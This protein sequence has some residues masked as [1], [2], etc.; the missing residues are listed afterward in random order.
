MSNNSPN[1]R[2]S[3][4][5]TQYVKLCTFPTAKISSTTVLYMCKNTKEELPC[6][7]THT[8]TLVFETVSPSR[9][10]AAG[11]TPSSHPG[12][13]PDV[14]A[15]SLQELARTPS[16]RAALPR[17]ACSHDSAVRSGWGQ[18]VM[19]VARAKEEVCWEWIW[20]RHCGCDHSAKEKAVL[21]MG[22]AKVLWV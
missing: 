5:V 17:Q 6:T 3:E 11:L 15:P 16:R 14:S 9:Q 2:N 8:H 18:V 4:I 7:H 22:G 19:G 21:G 13:L 20:P 12:P 10:T 1:P